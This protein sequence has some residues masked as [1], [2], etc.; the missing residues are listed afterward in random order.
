MMLTRVSPVLPISVD[1][2]AF[3]GPIKD[4]QNLGCH[5]DKTEVLT[6][7]GWTPWP[8]YDGAAQL[9]TV[10]PLSGMLEYQE[11]SAITQYDYDGEMVSLEHCSLDF[12]LTPNHR[13]FVRKWVESARTLSSSYEFV[14][15]SGIGWY[16][17]LLASPSGFVGTQLDKISIGRRSY[18]GDDFI[19]M[20]ALIASDGWVGGTDNNKNTVSFCCFKESRRPA[21]EAL[22]H[23]MELREVPSRRGVWKWAD[24]DL[25][26]WVR[27][28]MFTGDRYRSPFKRV[29]DIVKC[30]AQSQIS[31]FFEF[32]GDKHVNPERGR[33]FYTSSQR[34]AD[35][36]QELCLKIGKRCST[37]GPIPASDV[38]L[39]DGRE[40][41]AENCADAY[42][43]TEWTS[44][45]L[46]IERKRQIRSE[47]YKGT[48]FCATVPNST[49]ITRRNG[50]VLIS[51]NSCTGHAFASSLEWIFRKYLKKQP[52]LSPLYVYSKE[53]IA[54]GNFPNDDGSDGVT[55]C[56][57]VI[58]N[59]ACED[60]LYPDASQRITKPTPE[61]DANAA[62][63]RV[64][65]YHG[66]TGAQVA[67]SVLG[68][69][70]PWPVQIGFNVAASFE[71]DEVA[72]T[73]IYN[74]QPGEQ[75]VGGHEVKASGYDLGPTP[76]LRPA[77]CPPAFLIQN[78][79]S[80]DW[81][82]KGYFWMPTSVLDDPATDCKIVHSG[83]PW[84]Q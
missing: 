44:N 38:K 8:K 2:R 17:G 16:S 36:I 66:L 23:R 13:M 51:G 5:D 43:L 4:Q 37:F 29:P 30:A 78:S 62:Q 18:S 39:K 34:M 46:S 48:V 50:T 45:N 32:F 6:E 67:K 58:V 47:P 24:P 35:D 75:I 53:L 72:K 7:T 14:P 84:R 11:P 19:A 41:L 57:V 68:D 70:V 65:S 82:L 12:S 63:Y 69:P 49:L 20:L 52:I 28:N 1:L 59:G 3:D 56:N 73:G 54:D 26:H 42:T 60:S 25:A 31:M 27:V 10:N 55:G 33:Q 22:A 71:S 21:V 80:D 61:M 9:A 74:P 83:G 81:G 15:I 64:G 40:I 77:G 76:T 79:W